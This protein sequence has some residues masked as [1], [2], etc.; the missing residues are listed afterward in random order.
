M[1]LKHPFVSKSISH[2]RAYKF[3]S[4]AAISK[5][6]EEEKNVSFFDASQCKNILTYCVDKDLATSQT[7]RKARYVLSFPFLKTSP[8]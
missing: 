5:P 6:E 1:S 8:N 7:R 4:A 3:L 2:F